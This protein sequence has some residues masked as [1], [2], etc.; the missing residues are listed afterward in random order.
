MKFRDVDIIIQD[1]LRRGWNRTDI[2]QGLFL[3]LAKKGWYM[4]F[5]IDRDL[6]AKVGYGTPFDMIAR[7]IKD[8][9]W[10]RKVADDVEKW[11]VVRNVPITVIEG[12]ELPS[13]RIDMIDETYTPGPRRAVLYQ[14]EAYYVVS[15]CY[16]HCDWYPRG[17]TVDLLR[18]GIDD[19]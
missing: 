18:V 17:F 5:R 3:R 8:L 14:G 9:A 11:G 19:D 7:D 2:Y 15:G 1:A 6:S 10:W 4:T 12:A 16:G 13:C